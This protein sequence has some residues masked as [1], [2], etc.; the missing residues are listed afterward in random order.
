MRG[1]YSSYGQN[2]ATDEEEIDNNRKHFKKKI[3][4]LVS[5]SQKN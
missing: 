4:Q 5:C 3:Q 2:K 1:D